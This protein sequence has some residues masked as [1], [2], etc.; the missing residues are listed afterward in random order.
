L[1]AIGLLLRIYSYLFFLAISLFL[2][3][4]AAIA[5]T[6][7]QPLD[8][9]MLPFDDEHV[10]T[11]TYIIGVLGITVVLLA[12]FRVAK[13]LYPLWA[14]AT[15]YFLVKGY[16]FSSY[17]FHGINDLRA[18]LWFLLAVLLA[19]IGAVWTL[20]PRRGRLYS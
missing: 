7:H 1:K 20:K 3:G 12:L 17:V 14:A 16:F 8:L 11:G 10:L 15:L 19:F 2:L 6:S 4:V 5:T 13:F 9:R 18:T